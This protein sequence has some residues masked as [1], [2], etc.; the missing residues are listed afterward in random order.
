M[1]L[2]GMLDSPY[3]RRVAI[4]LDLLDVEFEHEALSVFS[5]FAQFAAVNPVVKAPTLVCDD[6]TVLMD[7]SLIVQYAE[8]SVARGLW[9]ADAGR[10]PAAF[11]AVGL[12]LAACEKSAQLIYERKLR[13]REKQHGPWI[14]RVSGQLLAAYGSLEAQVAAMPSLFADPG[15]HPALC[16]A[17]AWSFTQ[18][19]LPQLVVA[20]DYPALAALAREA[21]A[22]QAFLRR[23]AAGPGVPSS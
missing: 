3:V 23:P 11:G 8:A 7:S 1:R 17:V 9:P 14:E 21:E 6:G 12:A 22:T 10:L 18:S 15:E 2:I 4:T 19:M 16:A 13:P 20:A 5:T